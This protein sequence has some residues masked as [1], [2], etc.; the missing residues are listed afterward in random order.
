MPDYSKTI[1][2]KI[3]CK[4]SN[5]NDYYIGHTTNLYNRNAKHKSDCNNEKSKS[6]NLK[7]YQFIRNNGGFENWEIIK[8]EDYPC[9]NKLEALKRENYLVKEL[10]SSLNSDIPGRTDKE[11]REDNKE[12][13]A[14]KKKE[15]RE[16]NKEI[17]AEKKKEYSE[18]NKE[19]IAKRSKI[20]YEKNKEEIIQK[21]KEYSKDNTDIIAE[22]QKEYRKQNKE[23]IAEKKKEYLEKNKEEIYAKKKERITCEICNC[24]VPRRHISTHRKTKKHLSNLK[25]EEDGSN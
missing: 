1:I 15:Y 5:I 22:K 21:V 23:I 11:Y 25:L 14:E 17:I 18:N 20:Y 2:Y 6:Y 10:K 13:I 24:L 8:I 4:D 16:Q 12:I 3:I 7:V 9:E 19:K